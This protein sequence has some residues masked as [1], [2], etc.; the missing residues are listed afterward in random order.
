MT[1]FTPAL[2][3][4]P[5]GG[6]E[7]APSPLTG[8]GWDGG[9]G[10]SIL[11][12]IVFV[13]FAAG[14][15]ADSAIVAHTA[16]GST[17]NRTGDDPTLERDPR[18][19]SLLVPGPSRT[20][21]GFLYEW[22]YEIPQSVPLAGD[23]N[24]RF[25]TEFGGVATH[26]SQKSA[27]F[28][29]Y[30]DFRDGV[31]LNHLHLGLERTST[32]HYLDFTAGAVG[33]DDQHYRATLGRYGAFRVNLDFSQIPKAFTDQARTVF[34]GAGSGNLTL[35][36]GLIPGNN[37]PAQ[38]AAALESARPFAL[39]FIRKNA[40]LDFDATPDARWR[41]YAA[42]NQDRKTG[43]RPF[44][45]AA[46]FPGVPTV[47]TIEPIDYKTHNVLAGAQ[48]V[49]DALQANLGYTGSFFRN[50]IDTLTWENP[51]T[52]GDPAVLQRGRMD[53]YPD[54]NFHHLKLDA[55][56]AL[57]LRGRLT[58]SFSWS[59]MTQDDPLTPPTV[60]SGILPGAPNV[61]LANWNTTDALSTKS[62]NA[63]IDTRLV[64][65]TGS[66]SP[67]HDL[68][69]EARLRHYEEDNKTR[70]TAF[71][72]LTGQFG[73]LGTDG[74][75]N[76][77]PG[78]SRV[79]I[80]SVPFEYLKNNYGV[81]ADYRLLR[82]T[83][84]VL[85]YEREEFKGQQREYRE[86]AEDRV[87]V[88]IND[89]DIPWATMRLSYEHARRAGDNYDFNPNRLFYSAV[90]LSNAPATLAELR[91]YDVANRVQ[92]IVNGRVNFLLAK[93]M[94]LAASGRYVDNDYGAQYG[95][96]GERVY[97]F[98]L[99]W[100]WLPSP[101]ASAYAHYGFERVRNRMALISDDPAGLT[102]GNPSAG[103][104]VYPLSNLWDENSRDD[105]HIVGAGFRYAFNHAAVLES[106]YH[107]IY[108]PYRTRYSFASP[109]AIVGGAFASATAGNGMPDILF[110]QQALETS[111]RF[112]LNRSTA[113][114][115][116]HRYERAT[117]KDWHYDGL[118]LVLA[119]GDAVF[120]GAGPQS[121]RAHVIGLFFQYT[122]GK[123]SKR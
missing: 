87:R 46:S 90:S 7:K 60:N 19:M 28:R 59:R 94:D 4:P 20:P 63:R 31:V 12:L 115:L 66:F 120:L 92:Q 16:Q 82:R 108:S 102:T 39:G 106:G 32:A 44:A 41:I 52:V 123:Q 118:P 6:G 10:S 55:G 33:R 34:H 38:I 101:K 36:A 107:W 18:G 57:P 69:L 114:R 119:N 35:P 29:D 58:G 93:D 47:E 122:P 42:Y 37:S 30:R 77:V 81:E 65:L 116:F 76:I 121:Y 100:S 67:V 1:S 8:E 70:Y 73:Y 5:Q 99:E 24:Y 14:A 74:L 64:Q 26:R 23:W 89:R 13:S 15:L 80:R 88:A 9:V 113:L 97:V 91:K 48:W 22:P 104:A 43:T 53:L 95:R 109:G 84:L 3:L 51:L 98:N 68:T 96:L 56:A 50:G 85:G 49:N 54:N 105:A 79:Q 112:A 83:N 75:N 61:N 78:F 2:A 110:R 111:L 72:P 11:T 103:G 45:G 62:A 71:N 117:F 86:T 27:P 25:S 21:S 40:G 17:F